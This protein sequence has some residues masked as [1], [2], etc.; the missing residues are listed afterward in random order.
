MARPHTCFGILQIDAFISTPI[1]TPTSCTWQQTFVGKTTVGASTSVFRVVTKYTKPGCHSA[2]LQC[3][4]GRSCLPPCRWHVFP[5]I[6][7]AGGGGDY[8]PCGKM[9]HTKSK[10]SSHL[11][12]I[13]SEHVR[14]C[15]CPGEKGVCV[16]VCSPTPPSPSPLSRPPPNRARLCVLACLR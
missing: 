5:V 13:L 7:A 3:N 11:G 10:S 6:V 16:S 8:G 14:V 12:A 4:S 2:C 1:T 9:A 15:A